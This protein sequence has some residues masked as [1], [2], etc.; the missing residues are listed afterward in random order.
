[1]LANLGFDSIVITGPTA[2]GKSDVA[3][4]LTYLLK[5]KGIECF[6]IN[7]DSKQIYKEV[8]II[9]AQ[10]SKAD[11]QNAPHLL[12]G[13]YT[14]K[15]AIEQRYS[16]AKWFYTVKHE[17][18][19]LIAQKKMPIIVGG[20]GFYIEALVKGLSKIPSLD[21]L[22]AKISEDLFDSLGYETFLQKVLQLDPLT[23]RDPQRLK[24]NYSYITQYHK[25]LRLLDD[26]SRE[27]IALNPIKFVLI[28]PR[29][30]I[31]KECDSR[32]DDMCK[33]GVIEEVEDLIKQEESIADAIF[34]TSGFKYIAEFLN[35]KITKQIMLEK[36][37]QET[38]NY[39][40]R[41]S[42]W[43][44]NRFKDCGFIFAKS[45]NEIINCKSF[46]NIIDR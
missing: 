22:T 20:S 15:D 43:F 30:I 6:I 24:K 18:E 19:N 26:G 7:A 29:E 25:P 23:P 36:S 11:L 41:Q 16:V 3:I 42:T 44:N 10:P 33:D 37:K 4:K 27:I 17:V 32:F 13:F 2:S 34:T 31:Y 38:R 28:P 46:L 35:G 45:K 1:M 40:K 12:Y 39:A 5:Q 14:N 8:P 9:T 21:P